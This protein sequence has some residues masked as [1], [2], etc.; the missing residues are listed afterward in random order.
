MALIPPR[1]FYSPHSHSTGP[2]SCC[3]HTQ[4]LRL[5]VRGSTRWLNACRSP[6]FF[7]AALTHACVP[8]ILSCVCDNAGHVQF[9]ADHSEHSESLFVASASPLCAHPSRQFSRHFDP[10]RCPM[11]CNR[12]RNA[13]TTTGAAHPLPNAPATLRRHAPAYASLPLTPARRTSS[14]PISPLMPRQHTLPARRRQ[15]QRQR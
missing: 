7:N 1:Y 14:A 12:I 11:G 2:H 6:P 10:N 3:S 8:C 4:I 5:T 9:C 15:E 13:V